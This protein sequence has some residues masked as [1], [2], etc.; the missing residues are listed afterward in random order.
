MSGQA[1]EQERLQRLLAYLEQDP[2]N[3]L[4]LQDAVECAMQSGQWQ[5]AAQ[6]L[7]R[8][9]QHS[10]RDRLA[11]YQQAVALHHTCQH[12]HSLAL[13]QALMNEDTPGPEALRFLH[14]CN[15]CH[16]GRQAEAEPLLSALQP[17]ADQFPGLAVFHVRALHAAGKLDQ[18]MDAAHALGDHPVAQGMLSLIYLDADNLPKAR[19]LARAALA[20][21]SDNADALL[22]EASVC[23]A[24]EDAGQALPHFERV[25][26]SHPQHGRAWLGIGL[27]RMQQQD[28]PGALCALEKTVRLMPG[29]LGSWN[30]LAWL[31]LLQGDLD[32]AEHSIG[33][34]M[35]IDRNFSET[36][37]TLAVLM[38]ARQHWDIA[39]READLAVRLQ[40]DCF[41]GRFAQALLLQQRGRGQAAS[42]LVLGLLQQ[43]KAPAGGSLTDVVRRY[44][45]RHAHDARR[46]PTSTIGKESL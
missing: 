36:H 32:A 26:H 2:G 12:Q 40:H 16:V 44:H 35:A 46:S 6:L 23:L 15:L 22:A 20:S 4:L 31:Q 9:L 1:H 29:H 41:S 34:A 28:F 25:A 33:A 10:P 43:F 37:G 18:A 19:E 14:A 21:Q 24:M 27:A 30:A 17:A 13:T 11:R 5:L 7:D 45:I 8:V 39:R 38:A 3:L 42:K